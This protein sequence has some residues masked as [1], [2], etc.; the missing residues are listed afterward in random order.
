M[1]APLT[2]KTDDGGNRLVGV[3]A[4]KRRPEDRTTSS[5]V[6]T[7]RRGVVVSVDWRLCKYVLI[8]ASLERDQWLTLFN[9]LPLGIEPLGESILSAQKHFDNLVETLSTGE[10][11]SVV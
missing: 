8:R 7:Q 4:Y 2:W 10:S 9:E 5:I 3:A 6:E 11:E 1:G